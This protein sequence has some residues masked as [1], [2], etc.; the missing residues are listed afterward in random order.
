MQQN[1]VS[2][3]YKLYDTIENS[4]NLEDKLLKINT[5]RQKYSIDD[6]F[7]NIYY[8]YISLNREKGVVYTPPQIAEYIVKNTIKYEDIIENP[9]IKIVD[10]ACGSGNI[11]LPAFKYL[12]E[13]YRQNLHEINKKNNLSLDEANLNYHIVKNNLFG[14][15]IDE[16]A[17]K[18]LV[19]DLFC[20]SLCFTNNFFKKRL[21]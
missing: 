14:F 4:N 8:E 7:S 10:P 19:L 11:I 17:I 15:D 21:F 9:F 18:I 12:R 3:I 20:E 6:E 2:E 5:V 1:F 13:I 16:T